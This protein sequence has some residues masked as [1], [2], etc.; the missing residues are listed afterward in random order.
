VTPIGARRAGSVR[1]AVAAIVLAACRAGEDP[2]A[3]DATTVHDSAGIRIVENAAPRYAE[4]A[5]LSA[6]PVVEIS[7]HGPPDET[8]LD[9]VS[10]FRT[11][12]GLIVVG[13]GNQSGWHAMLVYDADGRFLRK[14]GGSGEGPGEFGQLW[15]AA[16]YRADSLIAMDMRGWFVRVFG[17]SGEYVR[18]FQGPHDFTSRVRGTYG[19][20]PGIVEGALDDG[21][22]LAFPFGVLDTSGGAGPAWYVHDLLR[23][24]ATGS[25]SD[26]LGRFGIWQSHW[27]GESQ[28]DYY[29]GAH[30][31]KVPAGERTVIGDSRTFEYR[32]HDRDGDVEMIVRR[33]YEP[34]PVTQVDLDA[35]LESMLADYAGDTTHPGAAERLI[36]AFPS[37]PHAEVKPAYDLILVDD[38]DRVWVE[39]YRRAWAKSPPPDAGPSDWSVFAPDGTWLM[40]VETPEDLVVTSISNGRVFG[41]RQD[42]LDVKHIEVY[43]LVAPE[44]AE[45]T[46][47]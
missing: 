31:F 29:F 12:S 25:V 4:P 39:R 34:Q 24:D 40:T 37:T 33:A 20:T 46:G 23:L 5:R 26:S 28:N 19:V 7:G 13:D 41:F 22:F 32:V 18:E 3:I 27:D 44:S 17:E 16:P 43:E 35:L 2:P 45:G 9:P 42:D 21:S 1:L 14:I 10:V 11:E 36:E 30:V 38:E 47:R 15:W 8:P 6:E